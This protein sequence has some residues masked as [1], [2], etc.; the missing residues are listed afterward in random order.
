MESL[1]V[2]SFCCI[3]AYSRVIG[4]S[5]FR[6]LNGGVKM[7]RDLVEQIVEGLVDGSDEVRVEQVDGEN[8]VIFNIDVAQS[9]YGQVVGKKGKN[10]EAIRVLVSAIS[11]KL[12]M[13]RCIIEVL[14]K[15]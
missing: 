4:K 13:K 11:V 9:D 8:N 7:L 14:D 3:L 2:C 1:L 15:Q 6:K 12:G 5:F 10:I